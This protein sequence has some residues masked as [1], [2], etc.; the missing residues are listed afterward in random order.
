LEALASGLPVLGTPVGGTREILNKL[1][2]KFLF[3]DTRPVS[4]AEKIIEYY[5]LI[6]QNP[7]KWQ[8]IRQTCRLFAEKNFSWEKNVDALEGLF[9]CFSDCRSDNS[10]TTLTHQAE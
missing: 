9:G 8:K 7:A 2:S 4:M 6:T 3:A 5:R 10:G 1:N